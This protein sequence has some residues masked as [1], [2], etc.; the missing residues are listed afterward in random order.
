MEGAPVFLRRRPQQQRDG[1]GPA[2]W[3]PGTYDMD[4]TFQLRAGDTALRSTLLF[5]AFGRISSPP[6]VSHRPLRSGTA[7]APPFRLVCSALSQH[8]ALHVSASFQHKPQDRPS[9]STFFC[10]SGLR[11]MHDAPLVTW[12]PRARCACWSGFIG[13]LA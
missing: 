13:G 5:S 7:Q 10:A 6:A 2:C 9:T 8:V 4:D 3:S 12:A 11:H 1:R